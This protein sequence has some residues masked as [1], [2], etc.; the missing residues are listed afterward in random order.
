M[1]IKIFVVKSEPGGRLRVVSVG[2]A[3]IFCLEPRFKISQLAW[4]D[5]A[6]EAKQMGGRPATGPEV[7]LFAMSRHLAVVTN[8]ARPLLS[9]L[10]ANK[11][12]YKKV[13]EN[14]K[15]PAVSHEAF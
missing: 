2:R 5:I 9:D 14:K 11:I 1:R 4:R 13:S 15:G 12:F 7:D 8:P 3:P 6:S 10:F